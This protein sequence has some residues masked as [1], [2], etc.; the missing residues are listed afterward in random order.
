MAQVMI[1]I[2]GY[3]YTIGCKDGEESHL[4]AMA[5]QIENRVGRAKALGSQSG[6]ARL[7]VM[8]ALLMADELHDM[9]LEL[10]DARAGKVTPSDKATQARLKRLAVRAEEV[11]ATVEEH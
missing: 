2:N 6:E 4:Q 7:L 9:S 8:A 3:A 5:D 1:R 10:K 11:A